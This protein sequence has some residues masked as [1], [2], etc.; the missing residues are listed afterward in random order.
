MAH[1]FRQT[2][3]ATYFSKRIIPKI[4][5]YIDM[6]FIKFKEAKQTAKSFYEPL[7][8]FLEDALDN[9]NN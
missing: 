3:R 9:V 2:P 5:S 1:E 8:A 4:K 7:D 6:E